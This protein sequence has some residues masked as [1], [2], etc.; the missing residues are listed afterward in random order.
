MIE[1][2]KQ[3]DDQDQK[4]VEK[5]ERHSLAPQDGKVQPKQKQAGMATDAQ[6]MKDKEYVK[7]I[8]EK[9]QKH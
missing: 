2:D 3:K 1:R 6:A 8:E 5:N 7:N 9:T 4:Q